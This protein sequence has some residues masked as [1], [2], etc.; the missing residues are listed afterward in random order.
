MVL[1]RAEP[2]AIGM[3][4][5]GGFID[6]VYAA[7]DEGLRIDMGPGGQVVHAPLSPG[8][9][10]PIPVIETERVALEQRVEFSGPGV[11]ALDGDRDHD[12][13]AGEVAWI[14]VCRDGP[15]VFDTNATMRWAVAAGMM[16]PAELMARVSN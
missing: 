4:P 9:F 15:R 13:A 5:I 2:N 11:I 10:K 6:P 12:L 7:D 8:L 3:S 16:S 1:T 14:T